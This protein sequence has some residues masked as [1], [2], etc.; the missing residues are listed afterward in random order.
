MDWKGA[1]QMKPLT[2]EELRLHVTVLGW[3]HVIGYTIFL[4]LGIFLFTLLSSIGALTGDEQATIVLGL[5]GTTVGGLLVVLALPGIVAGYGLFTHKSWGRYLAMVVAILGV[6][7]FPLGT[8][9][10]VYT[11]WVLLQAS[12]DTY[13]AAPAL[14]SVLH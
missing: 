3:L 6:V 9:V 5:V 1:R 4:L 10:G 13:F 12:A 11:L 8:I 7:N 14:P 2:L